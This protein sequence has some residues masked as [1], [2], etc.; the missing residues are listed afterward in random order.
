M[1]RLSPERWQEISPYL[2]QVL[3]LP[4]GER[5]AWLES[6]RVEKPGLVDLLQQLLEE[7]RAAAQEK[8]LESPA[9]Y[10]GNQ[11]IFPGTAIGEYA[12]IAPIGQGGMGSVWL[13]ERKDGRFERQVAVKFLH[14]SAAATGGAGRFKRE[15]RILGQLAHPHIAELIDAGVTAN[16]EPYLVLEYIDG[17]DID[18]YCDKHR[19]DVDSRLKLFLDVLSAV[20]HAHSNLIV[21]RDIKPSNVLVRNDG[22]VKLLDFGIAKLLAGDAG[23]GNATLLTGEGGGALTPQFAAPEQ[24]TDG[25]ITTATD[26][27][28]LGVLLYLLLTGQHPAGPGAHSSAG[29]IKAIVVT[30]PSRASDTV[31]S[32]AGPV[33]AEKRGTT[34][35]KLRRQLR[36][37]LDTILRK[38]QKKAPEERYGSMVAF[39]DDLQRYLK[40]EPISARPDSFT[41]R[42][43]KFIRRNKLGVALTALAVIASLAAIIAVQR[44]ARRAEYRFQ[45]VRK[46]AH[47][48]LFDLN[49][50]I[51]NLAGATPARELLVKTSLE[52]LD[53]L[54]T[55]SSNDPG[56]QLELATAYEQIGD[57]QG[58][59]RYS[60]LGHPEAAVE[61]YR[62]A[63]AIARMLPNSPQALE[64][65][66]GAYTKIGTVQATQLGERVEG[67]ENLQA[68]TKIADSIPQVTGNPDYQLRVEAYGLLGDVDEINEPLRAVAPIQRALEIAREWA[69]A[70]PGPRPR[71]YLAVLTKDW[72]DIQWGT[73]DLDAA[74]NTLS[75]SLAIFKE[76]LHTDPNNAEW[77]TQELVDWERM[78]LVSGHPD[79]FNLGDRQAAATWFSKVVQRAER[80]LAADPKD[81]RAQFEL[82][83]GVGELAAVYRDS[84][85]PRSEKLYQRS[86]ALSTSALTSDPKDSDIL[87][88]QSFERIGLASLLA[89]ARKFTSA[90]DQLQQAIAVLESLSDHDSAEISAHQL[91]G[92]AL[93]R[94]ASQ[95]AQLGNAAAADQDLQRSKQ[96][97]TSLYEQ[98]PNSLTL[99]RDLADC[100][101]EMG[102]LAAYR[103]KWQDARR[104]YQ[105]SLELWQRWTTIG[106]ST[107]Y[108][109]R[110]RE[111]AASLVHKTI[112]QPRNTSGLPSLAHE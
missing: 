112:K 70:D 31:F 28:A 26:V 102:K 84:D 22:Q 8:F 55:E 59:S 75:D 42:A 107:V 57:V 33:I 19:L 108:D 100:Y 95:L 16:G 27:Y 99:L 62:K 13:A 48:V 12:L 97:L 104:D 85:P 4:E 90:M 106:K 98:N 82:S 105:R 15:G 89:R 74:R 38:A 60:N 49:P 20:G 34:P 71:I 53:T 36:G 51:E 110:Q 5:T 94:R 79:F 52:Y 37:D 63:V 87:Y 91:L 83:E 81:V 41:Y 88:W 11:P 66:A 78:G 10:G 61:S 103:S 35:E 67:R 29:L 93:Q 92:L 73:G 86:L 7:H 45:Q 96:I 30:E 72:A 39:A 111:Q 17:E 24:V 47:S 64:V 101:R 65:I 14:F 76:S 2:D 40:R 109:Q 46:L 80:N 1:A 9:I 77:R 23:A 56:L 6:F 32:A 3:S 44:E 68:A 21:H 50:Q 69:H 18:Q 58:N 43:S 54:A 25:P